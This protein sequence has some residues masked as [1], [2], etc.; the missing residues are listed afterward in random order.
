MTGTRFPIYT[1]P[2]L[3]VHRALGMTFKATSSSDN[4]QSTVGGF[5]KSIK[6]AISFRIP[7]FDRGGDLSQLGGEFVLGPGCTCSYTHRMKNAQS[8]APIPE[9][10]AAAGIPTTVIEIKP[11]RGST[12]DRQSSV[13]I[14]DEDAWMARRRRS[15]A[16]MRR[17]R[18]SRRAGTGGPNAGVG[19][20]WTDGLHFEDVKGRFPILEEED[21]YDAN[22][23]KQVELKIEN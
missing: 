11:E 4:Y 23:E 3:S 12:R 7:L 8:H 19:S 1:D 18:Q 15:L 10:I 21:E 13:S 22:L 20:G 16:R 5:Y 9:I 6:D 14:E 2:T 17:K